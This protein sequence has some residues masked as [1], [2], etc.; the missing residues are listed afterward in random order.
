[1]FPVIIR[2]VDIFFLTRR[3]LMRQQ[4]FS[5]DS[6]IAFSGAGKRQKNPG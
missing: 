1:M 5:E 4:R 3:N 2:F 6:E